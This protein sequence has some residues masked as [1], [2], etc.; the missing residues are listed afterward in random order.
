MPR[1]LVTREDPGAARRGHRH[2]RRGADPA[3]ASLHPLAPL[4]D[5]PGGRTLDDYDWVTLTSVRGFE[6][7][8]RTAEREGWDWPP[9]TRSAAVGDRTADELT[10]HGSMPECVAPEAPPAAWRTAW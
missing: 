1:I 8:A 3:A 9:Q 10:A 6:A 7:I 5:V 2:G 4:R